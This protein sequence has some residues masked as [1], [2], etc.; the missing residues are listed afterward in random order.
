MKKLWMIPGI[1]LAYTALVGFS[2]TQ[3]LMYPKR[4]SDEEIMEQESQIGHFDK[5]EFDRL[6]K[7]D[8]TV[9]SEFGYEIKGHLAAPHDTKK[10]MIICHGISMSRYNSV[11]FM[12]IF[13]KRGYNVFIYDAR[14]HG[15]SGGNTTSFG[16]YEKYDLRSVIQWLKNRYGEEMTLGIHGESLGS[17]AML[18]YAGMLED[19]AD[20]YIA[21]CPFEDLEKL[22]LYRMQKEIQIPE[23]MIMP[24]GRVF[25]KMRDGYSMKEVS[26]IN[27]IDKIDKPIL[28][29]HS[30]NDE[31]I[32][33]SFSRNLYEKKKGYKKLFMPEA[34][35]HEDTYTKNQHD[36]E[37]A[38]DEFL[39]EIGQHKSDAGRRL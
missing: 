20:F 29:I 8:V 28:F 13:L 36:Y 14:R 35:G 5:D 24:I 27:V 26:P 37:K 39:E 9:M 16:H 19:G 18:L 4:R 17:A 12:N 15:E 3:G 38:I 1:A 7:L 33:S 10:V 30:K 6:E 23:F 2:L 25:L 11:K 22:L 34:G 21:D 32:P 31:T